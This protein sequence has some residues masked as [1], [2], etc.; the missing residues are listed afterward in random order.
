MRNLLLALLGIGGVVL[1]KKRPRQVKSPL[2][3]QIVVITGASA[4]IGYATAKAFAARGSKVV[5]VA[6]R[7][8]ALYNLAAEIDTTFG[9][10]TLVIPADLSLEKDLRHVIDTTEQQF[11]RI[12]VL[13]NNAGM[14]IGGPLEEASPQAVR[15]LLAVNVQAC[16]RLSQMVIPG[17]LQRG[18]GHIVNVSSMVSLL[19]APGV[20]VYA[21]SKVALNGF[22]NA[23]RRELRGTGIQAI[24]MMPGWTRTDMLRNMD[25]DEMR[26][27]GI[28]NPFI[29]ID[30]P[31]VVATAIV[32]AVRYHKTEVL[33]GGPMVTIGATF[34]RVFPALYDFYYNYVADAESMMDALRTPPPH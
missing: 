5:L 16:I 26:A 8:E 9:T 32:D 14:F 23:L 33:F 28:L 11:G 4:G 20:S 30:T 22:T 7:E 3:N 29:Y 18:K 12:D 1:W 17:M 24:N 2:K 34:A 27:A 21:A 13:I 6:R 25:E 15:R 31:E 10:P 19:G